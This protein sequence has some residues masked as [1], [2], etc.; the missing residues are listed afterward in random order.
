MRERE[1]HAEKG[2]GGREKEEEWAE[3]VRERKKG[4]VRNWPEV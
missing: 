2:E 3:W 4:R 1:Q